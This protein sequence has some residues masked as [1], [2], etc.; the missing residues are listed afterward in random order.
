LGYVKLRLTSYLL[1][2]ETHIVN[3]TESLKYGPMEYKDKIIAPT[4]LPDTTMVF[5]V[6]LVGATD[7]VIVEEFKLE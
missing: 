7:E 5:K 2:L 6:S 1:S 4:V 3:W